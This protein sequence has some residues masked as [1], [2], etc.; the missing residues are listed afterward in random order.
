MSR[1]PPGG[2]LGIKGDDV[3]IA[4]T[5]AE[6]VLLRPAVTLP[7]EIGTERR[8]RECDESEAELARVMRPLPRSPAK[9][10]PD[11]WHC[12]SDS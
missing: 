10:E 11:Q 5:T 12:G 2:A 9:G 8:I 3:V 7:T 6:G 4:E 1:C